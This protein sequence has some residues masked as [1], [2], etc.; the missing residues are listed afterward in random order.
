MPKN[1]I[2]KISSGRGGK[3]RIIE[4]DNGDVFRITE[5][6][7]V[8]S[9][10]SVGDYLTDKSLKEIYKRQEDRDIREAA[11]RLLRY[12]MR[13]EHELRQR[14]QQKGFP[15]KAIESGM[16]WLKEKQFINDQ[17]FALSFARE[18]VRNKK[19]GPLALKSELYPHKLN[20]EFVESII[21][22]VYEEFPVENIISDL[23]DKKKLEK[24]TNVPKKEKK[25]L[26]NFL[27]R[28]G[29][30]FEDIRKVFLNYGIR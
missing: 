9:P 21:E 4:L 23:L 26:V 16:H 11:F 14:L 27:R 22:K 28:K 3:S 24:G 7:F 17:E 1:K 15:E 29:F 6:V 12:R 10:L 2:I 18:K 20:Q 19:I 25:K 30:H 5:D 13:S 8:F